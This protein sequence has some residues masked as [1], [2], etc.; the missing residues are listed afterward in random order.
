ALLPAAMLAGL[1]ALARRHRGWAQAVRRAWG[2]PF[3]RQAFLSLAI[4][5]LTIGAFAAAARATGTTLTAAGAALA[6]PLILAAMLLP[7]SS[8][9][10]GWREGAA[11]AV[12]PLIGQDP[13]AGLSASIAYGLAC[14]AAALPGAASPLW[15]DPRPPLVRDRN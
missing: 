11:A 15:R 7:L 6:V 10:W 2:A 8:G 4:A 3:A 1:A 14:L 9:G 12:F 13:A 5:L